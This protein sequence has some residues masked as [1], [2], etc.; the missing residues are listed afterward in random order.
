MINVI[1]RPVHATDEDALIGFYADLS[2]DSRH[3]RFLG[4]SRGVDRHVAHDLFCHARAD[5]A[6]F[7]AVQIGPA[8]GQIV[9]HVSLTEAGDYRA[10]IGIVVLDAVQGRGIGRRLFETAIA[11]AEKNQMDEIVATAYSDNWRVIRLL[12]SSSHATVV[13]DVR[14]GLS[15]VAIQ[16]RDGA[17][18]R[19]G[20]SAER[21]A[22]SFRRQRSTTSDHELVPLGRS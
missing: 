11:W 22:R 10:E 13:R 6:G 14:C 9:G 15:A 5:E 19:P 8:G 17:T 20:G 12:G 4:C 1:I 21:Q 7:V 2:D 3:A 16:I 18:E